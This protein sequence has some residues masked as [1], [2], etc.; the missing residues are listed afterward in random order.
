MMYRAR[1]TR[2]AI[3]SLV[4]MVGLTSSHVRLAAAADQRGPTDWALEPD[5]SFRHPDS[6]DWTPLLADD[7]SNAIYPEGVWEVADGVL[8]AHE[9]RN[10]WTQATYD[11]F[12]LELEF[13]N[14]VGTNSGVFVYASDR[15]NFIPNSVEVQILDDFA[16]RWAKV[17]KSWQCG[18]IFGRLPAS[19]RVVRKP[20]QWNRMSI[21]CVGPRID[22][23]LNG[24][25]IVS[26]DMRAWTEAGRNPDGTESPPWLSRPLADLPTRGHIGFQGKHGDAPIWFRNIRIQELTD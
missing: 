24:H 22:V 14:D 21:R 18:A 1:I 2:L 23:A 25:H 12:V 7:L 10:L 20:G 16:E 9:D 15:D 17:P 26:M 11:N 8:T 6:S 3:V 13:K 4:A 5:G 19:Q